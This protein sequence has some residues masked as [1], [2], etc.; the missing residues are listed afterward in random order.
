[1]IGTASHGHQGA[2]R[3]ERWRQAA[4]AAAVQLY[5][6]HPPVAFTDRAAEV[7]TEVRLLRVT[8][9]ELAVHAIERENAYGSP[10]RAGWRGPCRVSRRSAGRL[11]SLRWADRAGSRPGPRSSPSPA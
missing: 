7:R 9:A 11:W 10:I 8:Q 4:T 1:V 5:D 2:E 3:A 6:G